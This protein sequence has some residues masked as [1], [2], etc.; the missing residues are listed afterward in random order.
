MK[1]KTTKQAFS[2]IELSVVTL[3]IGFLAAGIISG[4]RMIE[5]SR[6]SSAQSLTKSASITSI[7]DLTLWLE[8]TLSESITGT[9]NGGN[10][11]NG[12]AVLSWNDISGNKNNLTQSTSLNQPL[13]QASGI[14]N[15]PS[16]AFNG[17]SSILYSTTMPIPVGSG[18]YTII[19]VWRSVV[20]NSA[21]V[22]VAQ[23]NSGNG[24]NR[25]AGLWLNSA[26]FKFTGKGNDTVTIGDIAANN[27]YIGI[28]SVN[29]SDALNVSAYLN[30][31]TINQLATTAPSSL[32]LGG[33]FFTAGGQA[34]SAT[35]YI[36]FVNILLSE[37]IVFSRNLN[38]SEIRIINN[39]L[40]KK[41]NITI[42]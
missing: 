37:V 27:N 17:T 4:K 12:D 6:L 15:L 35:T 1:I 18:R 2:F 31:N 20:L 34:T 8:P 10:L 14:N 19:A 41:Y 25:A 11:S 7:P 21:G 13:Y 16:L 26:T 5:Q 32:N 42:S 24:T 40:S 28:V 38:P 3:L 33:G 39:Y 36:N 30:T 23:N 9:V 29:N 22:A